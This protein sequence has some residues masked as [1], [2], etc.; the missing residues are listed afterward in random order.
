M[1]IFLLYCLRFENN[2]SEDENLL[3]IFRKIKIFELNSQLIRINRIR[4]T[5]FLKNG[6][7]LCIV[8]FLLLF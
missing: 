7:F 1:K 2:I 8:E 5:S 3:K 6:D 4:R